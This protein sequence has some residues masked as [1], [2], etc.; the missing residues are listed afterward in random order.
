LG[1]FVASADSGEVRQL[2]DGEVFFP[3]W[4]PDG[5]SIAVYASTGSQAGLYVV[6]VATG[7]SRY[8]GAF[9]GPVLLWSPD[10]SRLLVS[11]P[12]SGPGARPRQLVVVDAAS[13][14]SQALG[15][16]ALYAQWGP[17]GE[18]VAVS[19]ATCEAGQQRSVYDLRTG[20]ITPLAATYPDA[21]VY[22][23]PDWKRIA[24]FK[25]RIY[26]VDQA[27][28]DGTLYIANFNGTAGREL[29]RPPGGTWPS[30]PLWSPDGE[31]IV[32][33]G[34]ERAGVYLVSV[35]K[36]SEP[37][38]LVEPGHYGWAW[39]WSPDS[40]RVVVDED[41]TAFV[42]DL[43]DGTRTVLEAPTNASWSPDS[44]RIAGVVQSGDERGVWITTLASR[45]ITKVPVDPSVLPMMTKWSP[46]GR[47]IAFVGGKGIDY[48]PCI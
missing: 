4:S 16:D 33:N 39:E 3:Q 8:L 21:S 45:A 29:F 35:D 37:V 25:E 47:S 41:Q 17:D 48:G 19:G 20:T 22:L 28:A 11:D 46:D 6:D 43:R 30:A 13:G 14:E 42:Y 15:T 27:P 7:G 24:Y 10:G 32:Y 23:S 1:L 26:H 38:T 36:D 2:W 40:T 34:R 31:S 9:L 18:R 44:S 12:G 5:R